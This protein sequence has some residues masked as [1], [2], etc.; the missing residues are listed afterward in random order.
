M[1]FENPYLGANP[2]IPNARGEFNVTPFSQFELLDASIRSPYVQQWNL[3]IQR[4]LFK[5][6]L[7]EFGYVGTK[8]TKLIGTRNINAAIFIPGQSNPGNVGLRRPFAPQYGPLYNYETVFNSNYH[9]FQFT[10]NKRFSRGFSILAAYTYSKTIDQLSIPINFETTP[11]Q[12]TFPQNQ[13]DLRAERGR[14]AFDIRQRFVISYVWDL[15]FFN[16]RGGALEKILGGWQITGITTF[17]TGMPLTVLDSSDPALDGDPTDRPDL[18][19]DPN[20]GPRTVE[21]FFNTAAFRPVPFGSGRY[22]T[23]G[24]NIVTGPGFNNFDFSL[25]KDF[26]FSEARYIQFRAEFFDLFNH[27]NF[28]LPVNDITSPSFGRILNTK[29]NSERQIQFGL[30]FYF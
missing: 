10:A 26:K 18:V 7:L 2:F 21:R 24:R 19:G 28:D 20:S 1:S 22:G 27:P 5:D 8:G 11:G 16:G 14:A 15:P 29:P 4:E 9:S 12:A 6:L 30:K 13:N 23:A 3:T 25:I 17:Q